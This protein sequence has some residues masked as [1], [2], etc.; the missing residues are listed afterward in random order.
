MLP[1]MRQGAAAGT[2]STSPFIAGL[3]AYPSLG[4]YS[5]AKFAV[6]GLSEVL[7][8][9][10]RPLGIKVT[11]VEPS[12]RFRAD[13]AGRSANE[14]RTEI[15]DYA[16]TAGS[17]TGLS[18][19]PTERQRTGRPGRRGRCDHRGGRISRNP[20]LPTCFSARKP[21]GSRARSLTPC[22]TTSMRGRKSPSRPTFR[23]MN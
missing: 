18:A 21:F 1:G 6:E 19:A 8:Q 23:P 9:E 11:L 16:A 2:L 17:G 3:V 20:P 4:Y 13:W 22:A 10:V 7:A 5:A 12:G 14:A 15:A